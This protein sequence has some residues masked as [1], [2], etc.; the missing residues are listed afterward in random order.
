[1][2]QRIKEIR[3][4]FNLTQTQFGDRIGVKGNTIT[5]YE[6]GNREPSNSVINSICREFG[7]N[8]E[9]IRFGTGEK[10]K[11]RAGYFSETLSRIE[12]SDDE[13]IKNLIMAYI[14][15]D[16]SSKAAL[17][18]IAEGMAEKYKKRS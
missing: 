10:Y 4:E 1:M 12:E 18:K 13:F 3:K 8:E 9:W 11:E 16:E 6:N 15:L 5:N 14:E 17:R 2:R 7:V